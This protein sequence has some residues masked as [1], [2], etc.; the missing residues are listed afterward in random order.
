MCQPVLLEG[1]LLGK[2]VHAEFCVCVRVVVEE[3]GRIHLVNDYDPHT[4][5][6]EMWILMI[7]ILMTIMTC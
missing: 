5:H 6:K 7:L 1:H 3:K 4:I 2:Q